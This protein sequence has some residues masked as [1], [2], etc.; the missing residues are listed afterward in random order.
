MTDIYQILKNQKTTLREKLE[1]IKTF[2]VRMSDGGKSLNNLGYAMLLQVAVKHKNPE[3]EELARKADILI[4]NL[5][6]PHMVQYS[7][8]GFKAEMEK[9]LTQ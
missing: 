4:S 1:E 2:S 5:K 7:P 3:D 9:A 6:N 8:S